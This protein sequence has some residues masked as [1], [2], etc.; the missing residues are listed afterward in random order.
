MTSADKEFVLSVIV[1]T[2][3]RVEMFCETLAGLER[4]STRLFELIVTDD[5][6]VASER[7]AISEAAV[8]FSDRTGIATRYLFTEP[9][10]GQARNTNQGLLAARGRFIRILHSDDQLAP[11]AIEAEIAL[12]RDP[13]LSLEFLFH[14]CMP[15]TKFPRFEGQPK[16]TLV[17]PGH[18]FR[19]SMHSSTPLPSGVVFTATSLREAGLMRPDLDF[20]CDWE[21]F[22][23]LIFREHKSGRFLGSLSRGFVGWRVHEN[24]TTGRLWHRHFL[25]HEQFIEDLRR[26]TEHC[27]EFFSGK[28]A[29]AVFEAHA[30]RY[31]YSRLL[32]D[33][34]RLGASRLIKEFSRILRCAFSVPSLCAMFRPAPWTLIGRLFYPRIKAPRM[35]PQPKQQPGHTIPSD[36]RNRFGFTFSARLATKI[37]N[38]GKAWAARQHNRTLQS[39]STGSAFSDYKFHP[40]PELLP[41]FSAVEIIPRFDPIARHEPDVVQIIAD[42]DN[43][44][45]LWP[46]R[47]LIG[48]TAKLRVA[49]TNTNIFH[50]RILHECLKFTSQGTEIELRLKDNVHLAGFGAKAEIDNLFPGQFL[51]S[52]QKTEGSNNHLL[53]YFRKGPVHPAYSAPHTGWT[54]GM[55]TSAKRMENVKRFVDS[56]ERLCPD[57]YEIIIISPNENDFPSF[58][59]NVR[60]IQFREH[61]DLGWITRKKNIICEQAVYSDLLICHDRYWLDANFFQ[62][63]AS[64]GYSYGLAAPRVRLPGGRRALDWAVV[65]SRDRAWSSGGLLSYFAYSRYAYN[66]GGATLIRR[67]FWR[68]FPWNENLFWNE[69]EDVE[70]CRRIQDAGHPILLAKSAV[71]TAEDRWIEQNPHI[72]YFEQAEVLFGYPVSEQRIVFLANP[73][74]A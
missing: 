24:S 16:L 67:D 44:L 37:I 70:L 65:S 57:P 55:L 25:E 36:P 50:E 23:R 47:S 73:E 4:Q 19:N 2:H 58:G 35:A 10:L 38:W 33:V 74:A 49:E 59:K 61:D 31:R 20:L 53:R 41:S 14:Y 9:A 26:N 5:S 68:D 15:F 18:F 39:K 66:P 72:P 63:F 48:N 51:W 30:V 28:Q 43:L 62:A 56:I 11:R 7:A 32:E 42:Y 54:F 22:A 3:S 12:M 60:V 13:Q 40:G 6:K 34:S 1:P 45:H 71:I 27:T 29:Q 46:L 69:H 52:N 21:F 8:S 64:W 17:Q